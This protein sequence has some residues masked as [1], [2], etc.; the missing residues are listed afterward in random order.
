MAAREGISDRTYRP[1]PTLKS[2]RYQAERRIFT[3][4]TVESNES[5]DEG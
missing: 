3:N 5:W 2:F 1:K 4:Q